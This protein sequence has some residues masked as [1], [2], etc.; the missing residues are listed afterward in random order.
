MGYILDSIYDPQHENF[1]A[2]L[3]PVKSLKKNNNSFSFY[4]SLFPN[5][6][7]IG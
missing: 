2:T 1:G 4:L 3:L 7:S 6:K 5:M